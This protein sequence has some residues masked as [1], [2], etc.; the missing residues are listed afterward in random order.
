[1]SE[2]VSE[3]KSSLLDEVTAEFE[4]KFRVEE[5]P[6]IRQ[7]EQRR[8]QFDWLSEV[9]V[10]IRSV[11]IIEFEQ[12]TDAA[13]HPGNDQMGGDEPVARQARVKSPKQSILL[14]RGHERGVANDEF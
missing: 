7:S 5:S 9:G 14:T 11:D 6:R 13:F 1:M 12:M 4:V 3:I 10:K 8:Q 2:P